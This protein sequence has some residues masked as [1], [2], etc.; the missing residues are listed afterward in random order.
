MEDPSKP[1]GQRMRGAYYLRQIYSEDKTEDGPSRSTVVSC[2]SSALRMKDHG[3]LM[4]HEFAYVLGQ[5]RDDKACDPL[6]EILV[7][8][9]EDQ[10][11]RHECAE[12]LG[13]ISAERSF[14]ALRVGSEDKASEVSE[15][16]HIAL[17]HLKWK[18]SG[19]D[20]IDEPVT[21]A[22]QSSPYNSVDPAPPH[23]THLKLST[24]E[25]GA[26][27]LDSTQPLFERY[28]CMFSLRNIG[29]KV[30]RQDLRLLSF[31]C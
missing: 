4:R 29:N 28:R 12:A 26:R 6:E 5:L 2:L 9:E 27:L 17:T 23:P 24:A 11:V 19:G 8:S 20:P 14:E 18:K 31:S 21:C 10:M 16:C 3:T 13:N 30:V 15:T 25:L 1:I 22:C 7:N